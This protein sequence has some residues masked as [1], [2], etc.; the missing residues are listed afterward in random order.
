MSAGGGDRAAGRIVEITYERLGRCFWHTNCPKNSFRSGVMRPIAHER[1]WSVIECLHCG[2][3]GCYPVGRVG[4]VC[5]E[6][7]TR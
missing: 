4:T 2:Q 5:S 1:E 3:R 6:E 7:A